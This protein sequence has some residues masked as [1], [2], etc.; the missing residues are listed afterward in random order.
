MS[1]SLSLIDGKHPKLVIIDYYDDLISRLEIYAEETLE[2]M[3]NNNNNNEHLSDDIGIVAEEIEQDLGLSHFSIDKR[4][5]D[6]F[7]DKYKFDEPVKSYKGILVKNFVHSERM[8]AINELKQMQKNRLEELKM[9]QTRPTSTEEALFGA[10]RS[11]F[12][13]LVN[14]GE[15]TKVGKKMKFRLLAVVVDFYLEKADINRIQY[16]SFVVIQLSVFTLLCNI[17]MVSKNSN[18]QEFYRYR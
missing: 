15:E 14:I 11:K 17:Y 9:T 18:F 13:F 2:K 3:K 8:K 6:P 5:E 16:Y 7:S 4:F 12:G 10:G 1:S